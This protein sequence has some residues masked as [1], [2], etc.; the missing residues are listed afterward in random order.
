[1][2]LGATHTAGP[3]ASL[4]SLNTVLSGLEA[5]YPLSLTAFIP[6]V[7]MIVFAYLRFPVLPTMLL[8]ILSAVGIAVFNGVDV[9]ALGKILTSGYTSATGVKQ[10]DDLLTRGGMLSIMPTVLLLCSG[11][12]FGGILERGKVLEV[13]LEA[14]LKGAKSTLRLVV[15]C[16]AAS[17]V[18]NLGTGSQMLAVIV[19]GRAF[20]EPFRRADVHA[21]VL[22]RTCEDAGTIG[23]PLIPWSVHAFYI[24]GV[25]GVGALDF[26]PYAFLNWLVPVFSVLCAATG[27]GIWRRDGTPVRAL[28]GK[29]AAEPIVAESD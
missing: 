9:A 4:E 10:L 1:M 18:I 19:P 29:V 13:V 20:L 15:S 8:C 28:S 6:P 5:A 21:T 27:F 26:G 7:I 22:S 16:L 2:V 24:V 12:A 25:L 3:G 14:M 17:Y 23:C 11:V